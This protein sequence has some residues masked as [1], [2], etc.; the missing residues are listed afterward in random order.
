MYLMKFG[1]IGVLKR[2][3]ITL[4]SWVL[5]DDQNRDS[6]FLKQYGLKYNKL[7]S[8]IKSSIRLL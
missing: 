3:M 6:V 8:T 1:A 4:T 2:S 7:E 5:I